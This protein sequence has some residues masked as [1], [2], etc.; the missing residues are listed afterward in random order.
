MTA[1][2]TC[3]TREHAAWTIADPQMAKPNSSVRE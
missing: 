1:I 2:G 3:I